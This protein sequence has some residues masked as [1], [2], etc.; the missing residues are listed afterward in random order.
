MAI[1]F[2][3]RYRQD[4]RLYSE[5]KYTHTQTHEKGKEKKN[6]WKQEEEQKATGY[7]GTKNLLIRT[8]GTWMAA[9]RHEQMILNS[10]RDGRDGR[11]E[12][13]DEEK[14]ELDTEEAQVMTFL[15]SRTGL[16]KEE[17]FG[18]GQKSWQALNAPWPWEN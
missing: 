8:A 3:F 9:I 16:P 1:L 10:P 12:W 13:G 5:I 2:R 6:T 15:W 11:G 4:S 14:I 18:A 7:D 17:G